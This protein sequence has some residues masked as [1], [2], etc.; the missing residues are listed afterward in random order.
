ML[1]PS[2]GQRSC[3]H[4][5][6]GISTGRH[7]LSCRRYH[8][9]WLLLGQF[10]SSVVTAE[11][12][13]NSRISGC[14]AIQRCCYVGAREAA[15]AAARRHRGTLRAIRAWRAGRS[16]Q[17]SKPSYMITSQSNGSFNARRRRR[18][19]VLFHRSPAGP[20]IAGARRRRGVGS[21]GNNHTATRP[22][23]RR[24]NH[25]WTPGRWTPERVP[26]VIM[27]YAL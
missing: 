4:A 15:A 20:C 1:T 19:A 7:R 22:P 14:E 10:F 9:S 25:N 27:R 21:V 12:E 11:L 6:T 26:S 23:M 24:Q 16:S 13:D 18:L 2:S 17:E 3:A 8:S 5:V